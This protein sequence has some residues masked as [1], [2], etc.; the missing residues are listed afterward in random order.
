MPRRATRTSFK[1]GVS[2]N[3]KGRPKGIKERGPRSPLKR[4]IAALLDEHGG[5][6]AILDAI[7]EGLGDRRRALGFLELIG[8]VEKEIGSGTEGGG[9]PGVIIVPAGLNVAEFAPSVPMH[10]QDD[11]E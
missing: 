7:L 4:A 1:P 6:A 11:D 8:K 3:P 2:G 5:H 10:S 9:L